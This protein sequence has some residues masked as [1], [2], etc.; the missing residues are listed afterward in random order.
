MGEES[1]VPP[2]SSMALSS[3][4]SHG[5]TPLTLAMVLYLPSIRPHSSPSFQSDS[6]S[7]VRR[8]TSPQIH[9][10]H[11]VSLTAAHGV[12]RAGRDF[13]GLVCTRP[14]LVQRKEGLGLSLCCALVHDVHS[15]VLF[16]VPFF[17][18]V[19]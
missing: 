14:G 9:Q 16:F 6:H 13:V 3:N 15:G 2:Q 8:E 4:S 18:S 10:A 19:F 5:G 12:I 11:I 17:T 1:L 7:N